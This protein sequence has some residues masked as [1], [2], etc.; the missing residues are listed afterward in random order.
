MT[1]N[2]RIADKEW[3]QGWRRLFRDAVDAALASYPDGTE[4]IIEEIWVKKRSGN[5]VHDY[6]IVVRP[7]G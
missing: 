5:A 1:E 3:D 7:S 4:A 6:R 2:F